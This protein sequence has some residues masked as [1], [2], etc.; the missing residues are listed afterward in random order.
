MISI[1]CLTLN[2]W[3]PSWILLTMQCHRVFSG[4]TTMSGVPENPIVDTKITNLLLIC[5]KLYQFIVWPYTNGGHLGF[6]RHF[7]NLE[8]STDF[9]EKWLIEE[10]LC[11]ISSFYVNLKV[12]LG[13]TSTNTY[14][15]VYMSICRLDCN[16]R[17]NHGHG[18]H[19][20]LM[21]IKNPSQGFLSSN[22][23]KFA[24]LIHVTAKPPKN[25]T[26]LTTT[27]LTT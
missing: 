9:P 15:C 4:H 7:F 23:A 2:K 19:F 18:G 26:H 20:K 13:T 17:P 10:Y 24:L 11:Q 21:Q 25:N 5:R 1:Y 16:L 12:V 14:T 6:R 3:R 8:Y 27:W 22:Q